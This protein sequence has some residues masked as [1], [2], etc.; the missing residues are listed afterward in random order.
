MPAL[1]ELKKALEAL[2]AKRRTLSPIYEERTM[3][4]ARLNALAR[5]EA[6]ALSSYE[7][8]VEVERGLQERS[9]SAWVNVY[10]GQYSRYVFWEVTGPDSR[11]DSRAWVRQM[12]VSSMLVREPSHLVWTL[13]AHI[14]SALRVEQFDL[15]KLTGPNPT[16]EQVLAAADIQ[17]E[18]LGWILTEME[19]PGKT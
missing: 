8:A 3:H 19:Y 1:P 12:D 16:V 13:D 7:A 17:L 10:K 5:M 2:E 9:L 6:E 11:W 4:E 14:P 18:R 15:E